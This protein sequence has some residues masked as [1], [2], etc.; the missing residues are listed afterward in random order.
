[1]NSN[2]RKTSLIKFLSIDIITITLSIGNSF[3]LRYESDLTLIDKNL[4]LNVAV[5]LLFTKI[6]SFYYFGLYKGIW[7]YTSINDL[8]NILK[9]SSL[10]SLLGL[11]FYMKKDI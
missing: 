5:I 9:A 4:L 11:S 1:M 6:L 10:G 3:F 7:R 8:I 2:N